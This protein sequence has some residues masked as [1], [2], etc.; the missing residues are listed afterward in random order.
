MFEIICGSA[1]VASAIFGLTALCSTLNSENTKLSNEISYKTQE[2]YAI[3]K[4][5]QEEL[6]KAKTIADQE[7]RL[8]AINACL[9]S[10]QKSSNIAYENYRTMRNTLNTLYKQLKEI[11]KHKNTLT[12]LLNS[13][14]ID[15]T[16][17]NEITMELRDSK[18]IIGQIYK[19]IDSNKTKLDELYNNLNLLNNQV[20]NYKNTK[21]ELIHELKQPYQ[22][23]QCK[24]CG[25]IFTITNNEFKFYTNNNLHLPCRCY[26]CR[27]QRKAA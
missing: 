27:Q 6:E 1:V 24:E 8:K 3:M 25:A 15:D 2:S 16:Q 12:E 9:S 13:N 11:K 21:K 22:T 7:T 17:K 18:K 19:N 10:A 26:N 20:K 23:K 14:E 5:H 4:R